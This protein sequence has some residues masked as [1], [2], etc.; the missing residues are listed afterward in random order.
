MRQMR[1]VITIDEALCNGCGQCVPACQEGAIQVIDGKARLVADKYC[2]GLGACLGDCP[3]GALKVVEREAEAFDEK[4]VAAHLAAAMTGPAPKAP[5]AAP[6]C[7]SAQLRSFTPSGPERHGACAASAPSALKHWPVQIRLVPP[8]APFL[9]GA[10]L[11]VAADC[12]P[13]AYGGLHQE[14]LKDKVV[15]MGCPK[16]DDLDEYEERFRRV[17][18]AND[19]NSVTVM[20]MEVPCCQGLPVVVQRAMEQASK[21]V[22]LEIVVIGIQGGILARRSGPVSGSSMVS[23][24]ANT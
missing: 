2:D 23:S 1:K 22:P 24:A 10:D 14:F 11:L 20:V 3:T 9:A 13:V 18:T 6:G 7:P 4:A 5:S 21:N 16:F 17:F 19:I 12:V 8:T 15:M